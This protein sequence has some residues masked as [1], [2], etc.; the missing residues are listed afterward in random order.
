MLLVFHGAGSDGD[1]GQE[2][3]YIG[4]IFRVQHLISCGHA[5]LLDGADVHVTQG[6][7]ACQRVRLLLRVRLMHDALVTVAGGTGLV[8]VDTGDNQDLVLDLLLYRN[9]T[10]HIVADSL[11]II[12]G[13][14]SDDG[15]KAV[16]FAG[17]NFTDFFVSLFFYLCHMV[18]NRI[19]F[20]D[21]L[22]GGQLLLEIE[23]HFS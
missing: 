12:C 1:V 16:R 13:T 9:Q 19:H 8:R 5:G 4:Q 2:I 6:D 11:F 3:L 17:E 7:D 15:D 22:G 21:F 10:A 23:C 20:T 14:G 18:G